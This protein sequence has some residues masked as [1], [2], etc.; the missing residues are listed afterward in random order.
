[1]L[2]WDT[3]FLAGHK[4]EKGYMSLSTI[5]IEGFHTIVSLNILHLHLLYNLQQKGIV[6][7]GEF[8]MQLT[9]E[10]YP[11]ESLTMYEKLIL[12]KRFANK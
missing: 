1:M 10:T 3:L 11:T 6:T 12:S 5:E 9:V 7:Y 4:L 2:T 8:H